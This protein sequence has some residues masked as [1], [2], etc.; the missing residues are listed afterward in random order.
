MKIDESF[1][2]KQ[3]EIDAKEPEAIAYKILKSDVNKRQILR[4]MGEFVIIPEDLLDDSMLHLV[5]VLL[6]LKKYKASALSHTDGSVEYDDEYLDEEYLSEMYYGNG[7]VVDG[8]IKI[9]DYIDEIIRIAG[10][11]NENN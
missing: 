1:W 7:G 10:V 5:W 3:M 11:Q 9:N 4:K 6:G 2:D 8:S